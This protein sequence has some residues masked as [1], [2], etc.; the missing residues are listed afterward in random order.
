MTPL[1][2]ALSSLRLVVASNSEALSLSPS[3][4]AERNA[5][6]AVCS[7]D[8]TD[9]LRSLRRSL[10]MLR[11]CCDLMLATRVFL[12]KSR[13]D[14]SEC[15]GAWYR[16]RGL[17]VTASLLMSQSEATGLPKRQECC[18]MAGC[19]YVRPAHEDVVTAEHH[20]IGARSR[21]DFG[22]RDRTI[23]TE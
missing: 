18:S 4:A 1:L 11:F 8:F 12:R 9:L 22:N 7:A 6:I 16:Q 10:V 17:R 14:C 2:A 13:L 15:E 3:A 21:S 23:L 5:R 20:T 19:A